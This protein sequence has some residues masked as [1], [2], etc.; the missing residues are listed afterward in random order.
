MRLADLPDV[1]ALPAREKL[2]LLDES[3]QDVAHDLDSLEVSETEKELLAQ[4]WAAFLR[5]PAA[6]LPLGQFKDRV[7]ALRP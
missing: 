5:D 6:A 2:Q 1:R 4:R 7:K 3:W